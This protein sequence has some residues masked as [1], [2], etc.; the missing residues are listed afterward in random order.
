MSLQ[1]SSRFHIILK[2]TFDVRVQENYS[3]QGIVGV[4]ENSGPNA[5]V[6]ASPAWLTR[7]L[8]EANWSRLKMAIEPV[9]EIV[10]NRN[11]TT[12]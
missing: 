6:M 11:G 1:F 8:I 3:L 4:F 5:E 10:K 12:Y 7:F 9:Y 2:K